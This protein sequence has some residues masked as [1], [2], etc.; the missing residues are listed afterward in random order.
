MIRAFASAPNV[1][2]SRMLLASIRRSAYSNSMCDLNCSAVLAKICAGRAC[3]PCGSLITNV[4]VTTDSLITAPR[5][6]TLSSFMS[7][8][9]SLKDH[10]GYELVVV[11]FFQ[12]LPNLIG[13][14]TLFQ[15]L[16]EC[17]VAKLARNVF[18][19]PEVIAGAIGGRNQ[20]EQKMD[21]FAV[22]AV[23]V[24]SLFTDRDRSE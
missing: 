9:I 8:R 13:R 12:Q 10:L 1:N 2:I 3:N 7:Q 21:L 19:R 16:T 22:Q 15:K 6:K 5:T 11:R 14:L 20:Q 23:E 17:V 4:R 18:Q 24:D